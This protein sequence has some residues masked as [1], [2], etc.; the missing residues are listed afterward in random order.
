MF[1]IP[2]SNLLISLYYRCLSTLT[3]AKVLLKVPSNIL[4]LSEP[5]ML[6]VFHLPYTCNTSIDLIKV[7]FGTGAPI[8]QLNSHIFVVEGVLIRAR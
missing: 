4:L 1:S 2:P 6:C 5:R 7:T 8:R 3:R